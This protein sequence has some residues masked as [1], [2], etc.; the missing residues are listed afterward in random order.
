MLHDGRIDVI[1]H[2]VLDHL[3]LAADEIHLAA[4]DQ[5]VSVFD[6]DKLLCRRCEDRD[7][8]VELFH[9][10]GIRQRCRSCRH[11][12]KLC[13]VAAGMDRACRRIRIL[14]AR[15][16]DR[17]Q[18]SHQGHPEA[19]AFSRKVCP[20]AGD[21]QPV[22]MLYIETVQ[23]CPEL[24]GG[25]ELLVAVFR[26]RIHRLIEIKNILLTPVYGITQDLLYLL[27]AL[28]L[29]YPPSRDRH[30]KDQRADP[31]RIRLKV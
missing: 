27:F 20:Y 24:C 29:R 1:K 12:G 3:S 16:C 11:G 5:L 18:F 17:V 28:H 15:D 4:L 19:M 8:A 13:S 25:L 21:S 7:I 22:L 26:L 2:A 31:A 10:T 6:L 14:M 9:D 30:S 23:K